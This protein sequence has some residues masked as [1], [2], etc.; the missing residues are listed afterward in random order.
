MCFGHFGGKVHSAMVMAFIIYVWCTTDSPNHDNLN[1][2]LHEYMRIDHTEL[3]KP[4][5]NCCRCYS[6]ISVLLLNDAVP[7][8]G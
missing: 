6:E 7:R 3:K 2:L 1:I 4:A 5:G 8:N